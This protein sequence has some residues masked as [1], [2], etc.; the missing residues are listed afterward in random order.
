M[1]LPKSLLRRLFLCIFTPLYVFIAVNLAIYSRFNRVNSESPRLF[2]GSVPILNNFYWSRAMRM[3]GYQAETFVSDYYGSINNRTDWDVLLSEKYRWWPE[4]FRPFLGFLRVIMCYD[5]LFI[6]CQGAFIGTSPLWKIQAPILKLAAKK[7]VV[8]PFG[9]DAYV[10][11]TVR[12]TSLLHGLLTSYPS[13]S[14]LQSRISNQVE[15]WCKNADIFIPG[16]MSFDG[17]G[18]W[19]A[20]LPSHLF[21][22]TNQW[23]YHPRVDDAD[24]TNGRVLICHAPNHRGFKGTEF[25]VDAV[26]RL[27]AQGLDVELRLIEGVQNSEVRRILGDEAHILVE[28]IVATGHA[29]NGLE[30]M[31]SGIPVVCN[32]EDSEFTLPLKRWSY[33]NECPIVSASPETIFETLEKLV[34]NPELRGQLGLACRLYTEKYHGL[35]SAQF[36]FEN[37]I[38]Y[39]YGKD[40]DL[41]GLY[42]PLLG[43]YPNRSPK[44]QHPLKNNRI[45]D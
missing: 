31:A 34:R 26:D 43:E 7:I 3:A 29:L 4:L 19:D 18:R 27:K 22:D 39:L 9:S 8:L 30:G 41:L 45:V 17:I 28:Q 2:F 35:D 24:G 20:L 15:Y 38:A 32:L 33:L 21:I 16:V 1:N 10:Y 11:R 37:V 6:S 25:V 13:Q 40:V 12:S 44:I 5:V 23:L 42:H 14:R 36:L